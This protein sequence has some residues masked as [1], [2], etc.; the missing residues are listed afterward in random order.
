[1]MINLLFDK[2]DHKLAAYGTLIP[3]GPNQDILQGVQGEWR[4]CK[5]YGD[6]RGNRE[7]R[8]FHW[9]PTGS[10]VDASLLISPSLQERWKKL[11]QFEGNEYR[12]H[13]IPVQVEESWQ[14]ANVYEGQRL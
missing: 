11:D 8:A 12:R 13:L 5:V 9:N 10:A 7:L 1:M 2:P 3:G 4:D 14:I 6:V